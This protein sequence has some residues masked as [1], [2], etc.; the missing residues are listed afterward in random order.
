M[1]SRT[2]SEDMDVQDSEEESSFCF[3]LE[4]MLSTANKQKKNEPVTQ[5][6]F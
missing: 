6:V 3:K 2:N 4:A 1:P 5:T